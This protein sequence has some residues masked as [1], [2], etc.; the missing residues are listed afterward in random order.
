MPSRDENRAMSYGRDEISSH[1]MYILF[2]EGECFVQRL[3]LVEEFPMNSTS[4]MQRANQKAV[5]Q[6]VPRACHMPPALAVLGRPVGLGRC[7]LF[8]KETTVG[9]LLLSFA[10]LYLTH[11]LSLYTQPAR[12]LDSREPSRNKFWI[13][14]SMVQIAPPDPQNVV[15]I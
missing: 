15:V 4:R 12:T 14:M 10:G 7:F 5:R 11:T 9:F 1:R 2:D 8:G 13:P 6:E 3:L